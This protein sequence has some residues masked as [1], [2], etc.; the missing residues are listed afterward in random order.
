MF[1]S[2]IP[3]TYGE[4]E[5]FVCDGEKVKFE[6][7]KY[8]EAFDGEVRVSKPNIY[9]GDSIVHLTV[10]VLPTYIVDE[11]LTMTVGEE[12][13]WKGYKLGTMPVGQYELEATYYTIN[14][15]DSTVVLHLTIQPEQIETGIPNL[16]KSERKVQKVLYNGNLYII[17]EDDQIYDILGKKIK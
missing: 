8:S 17:R 15:C 6:G 3:V 5:A 10:T 2:D 7:V 4:Y 16:P 13:S 11:Y 12:Q 14:D 9:G 1:V